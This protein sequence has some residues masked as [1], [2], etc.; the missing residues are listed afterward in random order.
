MAGTLVAFDLSEPLLARLRSHLDVL[1]RATRNRCQLVAG[2][3]DRVAERCDGALF[4]LVLG[5]F[6]LHHVY[7]L[8]GA[9]RQLKQVLRP[10]GR[11]IFIEPNRRNPLFLLQVLCCPGMRWTEERGMFTLGRR[12]IRD[13]FL[14]AGMPVPSLQTFGWFPPQILDRWP[15]ALRFEESIEHLALCRA[16]LPFRLIHSRAIS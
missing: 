11:M 13:A 16:I 5:F 7:D 12:N 15:S 6:F 1:D 8:S 2:D 9:L 10:G 4:D 3:I 14:A